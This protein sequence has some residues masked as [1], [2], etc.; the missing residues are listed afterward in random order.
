MADFVM[1]SLGADMEEGTVLQWLVKP[2]DVVHRGD[3]VA[4]VDTAKAA[5]D[6]EVFSDGLVE[7]LLVPEGTRVPVGTPLA[8]LG[9]VAA[10]VSAP[11]TSPLVRKDARSHGVDLARVHGTGPGGRVRRVDVGHPAQ[12]RVSPYARRLARELGVDLGSVR[13]SGPGGAVRADDVRAAA[14]VVPAPRQ[15]APRKQPQ[16]AVSPMRQT[17]ARAMSRSWREVP[18]Y[19][20]ASS[21]DLHAAVTWLR[22]TNLDRPVSER[23]VP[24]ALLLEATALA[25]RQVPQ[26]NGFWKDDAFVESPRVHLGVAVSLRGGGLVA[27]ALMDADQLALPDLMRG[28]RDLVERARRGRLRREELESA[29][30]TVT[31]LGDLGVEVV[32][33]VVYAPQVALVGFG[34]VVER[35]WAVDGLLGVRPVVT[36]TLAADHRATDGFTGARFLAAVDKHLQRPEEL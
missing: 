9:P 36:A 3:V 15:E 10:A 33:G 19:H 20:L 5:V 35:P 28:L 24:A 30:V 21:I 31:N 7:T 6:V 26:L 14:S 11:V 27:P 4:V 2:G 25:L 12:P 29:T 8:R 13:G 32:H 23:I 18:H 1:P 16:A 34:R 17:I 22:K